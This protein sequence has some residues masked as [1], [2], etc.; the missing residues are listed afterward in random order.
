M[1]YLYNNRIGS[2]TPTKHAILPL[3]WRVASKLP[4]LFQ[5]KAGERHFI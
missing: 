3:E 4:D 2:K 5:S 1:E